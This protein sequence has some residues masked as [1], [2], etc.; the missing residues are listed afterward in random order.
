LAIRWTE[1]RGDRAAYSIS[2]MKIPGMAVLASVIMHARARGT[3]WL[4]HGSI[5][6]FMMTVRA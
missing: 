2:W 3:G 6:T 1:N 4:H 5:F